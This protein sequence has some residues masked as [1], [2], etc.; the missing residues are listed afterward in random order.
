MATQPETGSA[1]KHS[2][3]FQK[4]R[5]MS[6]TAVVLLAVV[7]AGYAFERFKEWFPPLVTLQLKGHALVSRLEARKP[8]VERVAVV[9]IDDETYWKHLGG[10]S[11][12]NRR[13]LADVAIAAADSNAAVIAID[14]DLT[15]LDPTKPGD[16]DARK[17]DNEALLGPF[18][19]L[20][21]DRYPFR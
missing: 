3:V 9:E 17:A 7:V 18:G 16:A 1:R 19:R 14:I 12:T 5:G 6:L 8:R 21:Q 20:L 4:I 2:D 11:P 15:A 10:I 13:F